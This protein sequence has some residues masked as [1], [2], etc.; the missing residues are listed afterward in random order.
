MS[1]CLDQIHCNCNF[2][3]EGKRNAVASVVA[4]V[5]FF[6]AWWMMIDTAAVYGKEDWNNVYFI[7]TVASTVAMFMVNAVSNS[8]VRGESLSEGLLGTKG[9]FLLFSTTRTLEKSSSQLSSCL[10]SFMN[11]PLI[12]EKK[13]DAFQ[14]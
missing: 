10:C 8:Q 5:L 11:S 1:G 7:I 14:S 13:S 6:S 9:T 2:D 3:F 4:S 12:P